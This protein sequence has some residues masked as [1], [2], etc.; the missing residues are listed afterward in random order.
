MNQIRSSYNFGLTPKKYSKASQELAQ[1]DILKFRGK[2]SY[3]KYDYSVGDD[4]GDYV[5]FKSAVGPGIISIRKK[6]LGN[7]F[8]GRNNSFIVY[9]KV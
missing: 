1:G 8:E 2:D 4:K 5:F 3:Y 9:E 7:F 6:S